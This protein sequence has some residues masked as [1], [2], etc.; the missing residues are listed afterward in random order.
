MRMIVKEEKKK[1]KTRT[2]MGTLYVVLAGTIMLMTS[3]GFAVIFVR[4]GSMGSV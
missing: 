3:S 2:S 1:R 4:D